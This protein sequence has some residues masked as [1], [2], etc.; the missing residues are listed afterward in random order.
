[1]DFVAPVCNHI[2]PSCLT[3]LPLTRSITQKMRTPILFLTMLLTTVNLWADETFP[4]LKVG[5]DVYKKVTVTSVTAT[6]IYFTSDQGMGNAKLKNLDPELQKHFHYDSAKAEAATR[7]QREAAA[8]YNSLSSPNVLQTINRTNAQT[9]RDMAIEKVKAIINQPVKSYPFSRSMTY[10]EIIGGVWFHPGATKP[11]FNTVDIRKTQDLHYGKD[12]NVYIIC[13]QNPGLAFLGTDLEF[14]S[15]TKYFY[16]DRSLPKK[17]LT[18]AEML[19]IN[20]LYR[21]IGKC[22]EKLK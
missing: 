17:K 4:T 22:D 11:D 1:M 5:Q 6:D 19:E 14:N 12:K 21:I 8:L 10:S 3:P 9:I 7:K 15:M 20:H 2:T 16:V 13:A 18:E